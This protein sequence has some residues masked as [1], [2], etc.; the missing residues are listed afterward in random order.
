VRWDLIEKF[1]V[2]KKGQFSLARKSFTGKEDFFPEHYAGRPLVPEPLLIEMIAQAGG[3]LFGVEL[4]FKKEVVLV[5]VENALFFKAVAPP[6]EFTIEAKL[7]DAHEEGAWIYG[8]VKQGH[9]R[10]AEAKIMLA[11]VDSLVEGQNGKI[12]FSEKFLK[13]YDIEHVVK[14]SEGLV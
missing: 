12:I 7:E 2:L 10:V 3:V 5:K 13:E 4:G 9:E 6:C 8:C 14:M 11:A 1:D